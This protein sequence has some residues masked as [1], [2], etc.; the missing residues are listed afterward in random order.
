MNTFWQSR[1]KKADKAYKA[2]A[3]QFKCNILEDYY[4]GRQ[5]KFN[6]FFSEDPYVTNLIYSTIK[7]K[8]A[9]I[10]LSQPK[11][12]ITPKPGNAD[13]NQEVAMQSAQTKE[14]A[15]NAI[16][17]DDLENFN[18]AIKLC[19]L[20][21]MFR[22]GVLEVGYA[23]DWVRNPLAD[24][25]LLNT[26]ETEVGEDS[27]EVDPEKVKIIQHPEELPE[28]EKIYFKHIPAQRFRVG[29]RDAQELS[30]CDWFG[31]YEFVNLDDLRVIKGIKSEWLDTVR[32]TQDPEIES[33]KTSFASADEK[34]GG[35][36]VK[37]WH[38]FD[39]RAK[40]RFLYLDD[41]S[42][43][44]WEDI[45][46][47]VKVFDIRWDIRTRGWY[48][49][50][51]V[52]HWLSPQN[53]YNESREQMRSH[54]RRFNRKFGYK[55][56]VDQ[57]ELD[58]FLKG[59]DGTCIKLENKECLW[60]IENPQLDGLSESLI[61][62]KDDFNEVSGTSSADRGRADRTTATESQR[63]GMKSDI[64]DSAEQFCLKSFMMRIG[65]EA[66]LTMQ[67]N[68]DGGVWAKLVSDPGEDFLGD[69]SQGPSFQFIPADELN[70]GYDFRIACEIISASPL[71]NEQEEKA[72]MKFLAIVNTYPQIALSPMLVREA[73]YRCNY[74][75]ERVI[76]EMQKIAQL[77]ML[78]SI[79]QAG[80]PQQNSVSGSNAAQTQSAQMQPPAM[81]QINNQLNN[82]GPV[83]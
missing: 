37:I 12:L 79:Q 62:S 61:I 18:N 55:E 80:G 7:I 27:D 50:P 52:Y 56:S 35:G 42:E 3:N 17:S 63:L 71:V 76:R 59:E 57:E 33:P 41:S 47:R 20:D 69:G 34:S 14:D 53:E 36:L 11:Y 66:L 46:K 9:N 23:A 68:F 5:W 2:W 74:R 21:S 4:E 77:T 64:R 26:Q 15:L 30:R 43:I 24:K 29:T 72:F 48:P 58:K 38:L 22:F 83:I 32:T 51:P 65:R 82:Q 44:I 25:P 81:E 16:V 60:A 73:A 54:R 1:I 70:D 78:G 39:C 40:K 13:Y 49:M 28:N 67:E 31:Y 8:E 10:L 6:T 45:W 75:N 19:F